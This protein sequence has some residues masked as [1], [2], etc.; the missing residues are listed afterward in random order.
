M[1]RYV[2]KLSWLIFMAIGFGTP[3]ALSA[4]V[5][6]V[7]PPATAAIDPVRLAKARE[8]VGI[9]H[10]DDQL[11]DNFRPMMARMANAA[12]GIRPPNLPQPT[13]AQTAQRDAVLAVVADE[14]EAVIVRAMPQIL[15]AA[16]QAYAR[17][18]TTAELDAATA[19]YRTPAGASFAAKCGAISGD[20]GVAMQAMLVQPMV[21]RLPA[22]LAR[23][24]A[25]ADPAAA[26]A[27]PPAKAR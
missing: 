11:G 22:I 16:A 13:A 15:D 25:M 12:G 4:S 20:L 9:M 14:M 8:L 26:S 1:T 24:K 19:F 27:A 21:A 17:H 23:V 7:L 5:P 2:V 6:A 10:L 18:L 3:A